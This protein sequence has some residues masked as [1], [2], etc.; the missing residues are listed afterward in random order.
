MNKFEKFKGNNKIASN[1]TWI[2]SRGIR[3]LTKL[4]KK[5][6]CQGKSFGGCLNRKKSNTNA[7]KDM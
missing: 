1:L 2:Y 3:N 6:A 4:E 5:I 7:I